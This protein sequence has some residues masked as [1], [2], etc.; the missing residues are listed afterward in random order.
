LYTG[1]LTIGTS[2]STQLVQMQ[3]KGIQMH[4]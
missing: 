2:T 1:E 4:I 3:E